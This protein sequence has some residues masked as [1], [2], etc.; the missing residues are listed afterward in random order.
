M[1]IRS[2]RAVVVPRRLLRAGV[3]AALGVASAALL[4][5][6]T[7]TAA[8]VTC[9]SPPSANEILVSDADSCGATAPRAARP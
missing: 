2:I 8:P 4:G 5:V 9:V 3:V 1:S 7:A 6:G